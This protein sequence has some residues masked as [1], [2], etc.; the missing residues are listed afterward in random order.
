VFD[1]SITTLEE[2]IESV[3]GKLED[4]K[5]QGFNDA[6][7]I[8]KKVSFVLLADHKRVYNTLQVLNPHLCLHPFISVL[9]R[10]F[11]STS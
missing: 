5:A 10:P 9:H 2:V 7:Y 8:A 4:L 1:L 6:D 11:N 3:Y